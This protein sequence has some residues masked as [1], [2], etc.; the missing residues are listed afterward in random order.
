M[1]PRRRALL[2][3]ASLTLMAALATA[4]PVKVRVTLIRWPYT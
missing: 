3:T 4:A 1:K 2:M